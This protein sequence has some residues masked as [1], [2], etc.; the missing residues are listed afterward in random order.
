MSSV[1]PNQ[2]PHLP[3]LLTCDSHR[4]PEP[5]PVL[6]CRRRLHGREIRAEDALR[7][8]PD[9]RSLWQERTCANTR[10]A[11]TIDDFSHSSRSMVLE[12]ARG[13]VS[14]ILIVGVMI[15]DAQ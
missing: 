15:A 13:L 11:T 2:C 12:R 14:C 3:H 10:Y 6:V 7:A 8:P 5:D 9:V 1:S 4:L